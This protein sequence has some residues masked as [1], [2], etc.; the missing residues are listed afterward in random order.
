M[1]IYYVLYFF[2]LNFIFLFQVGFECIIEIE[3]AKFVVPAKFRDNK[4]QCNENQ[5]RINYMTNKLI[6]AFIL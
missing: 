4:V 6:D 2:L 3:G 1:K 5:V